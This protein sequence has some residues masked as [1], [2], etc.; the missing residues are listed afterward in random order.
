LAQKHLLT[1]LHC[2]VAAV[3]TSAGMVWAG[4]VAERQPFAGLC[5]SLIAV[6]L[7]V[8][9]ATRVAWASGYAAGRVASGQRASDAEPGAAPDRR[10][11]TA[12]QG[13]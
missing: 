1:I 8:L 2:A 3:V 10:G 7:P 9:I 5:L 12:S 13:S 11:T 4:T 6:V